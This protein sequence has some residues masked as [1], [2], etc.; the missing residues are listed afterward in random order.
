MGRISFLKSAASKYFGW[1]GKKSILVAAGVAAA[2][3]LGSAV[4][5]AASGI[6]RIVY[7]D[8]EDFSLSQAQKEELDSLL[9]QLEQA[10][11]VTVYGFVQRSRP[12]DKNKGP[13]RL[14]Y[15][16]ADAV[17]KHLQNLVK[18]GS[19]KKA[20]ITWIVEGLGQPPFDP[21][22]AF[23]RRVEVRIDGG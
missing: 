19:K 23:A 18:Q 15:K 16:R 10:S 8:T 11:T 3:A 5:F 2:I 1:V 21:G 12:E 6:D 20:T 13:D 22:T 7:F 4:S 9:P 17:A 14:S